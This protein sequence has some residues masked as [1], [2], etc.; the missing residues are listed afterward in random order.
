M[1]L[2]HTIESPMKN[3]DQETI[4]NDKDHN[5]I[6]NSTGLLHK[7]EWIRIK[8]YSDTSKIKRI[9][10]IIRKQNLYSVCEEAACPN[11]SECFH[12]GT[13]TFMILGSICTRRCP[14]C[15]VGKG[16]PSVIDCNEPNNLAQTIHKLSLRYVVITSVDRDDLHDGGAQHFSN[17]IRAIRDK[18][19]SIKIEI[20]VPDFRGSAEKALNIL[21]ATPPDIFNHNIEN[22][23]R[24]YHTVRPGA[25]YNSSL[26]L[27]ENFKKANP[28]VP[29]KSGLILGLGETNT[30]LFEVMSHLRQHGVTM[31]TIGQYLQPSHRHLSVQRYVSP[32]E[33]K[34]IKNIA[35]KMGFTH[36]ACGPFVRSSYHADMQEQGLE[37]K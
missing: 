5:G 24:M 16:R 2:I 21:T 28:D 19:P 20:L 37:V 6:I 31:L 23:P 14:F 29:T 18:N 15:N 36:A 12:H 11:L 13:A 30:E 35:I 27:L 26:K 10:S 9:K 25:N 1:I 8:F 34:K 33:F 17:C 3:S 4:T 32:D 22:V 7:P